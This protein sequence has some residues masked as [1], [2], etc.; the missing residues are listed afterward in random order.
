MTLEPGTNLNETLKH[1]LKVHT[2]A[3]DNGIA[4]MNSETK[5]IIIVDST[6]A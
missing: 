5:T 4:H 6:V 3:S 2:L 1:F